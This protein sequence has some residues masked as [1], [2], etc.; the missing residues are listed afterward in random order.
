MYLES[1]WLSVTNLNTVSHA[2]WLS[3]S[4]RPP[5]RSPISRELRLRRE[6]FFLR[7]ELFSE[8]RFKQQA[9]HQMHSSV[10]HTLVLSKAQPPLIVKGHVLDRAFGPSG[11]T[12]RLIRRTS[13]PSVCW[14]SNVT[15]LYPAAISSVK[16]QADIT[17][18]TFGCEDDASVVITGACAGV[19]QCGNGNT[20]QCKGSVEGALCNCTEACARDGCPSPPSPPPP[21]PPMPPEDPDII[22]FL[23]PPGTGGT[24]MCAWARELEQFSATTGVRLGA[25][26]GFGKGACL[27][28]SCAPLRYNSMWGPDR[29]KVNIHGCGRTCSQLRQHMKQHNATWGMLES[30]MG[31]EWPC[32]N[33]VDAILLREPWTRFAHLIGDGDSDIQRHR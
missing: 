22:R 23:H 18:D 20:T 26:P 15:E 24:T 17:I 1:S 31:S 6:L 29:R 2:L 13:H 28:G 21:S 27:M 33:V 10:L 4:R 8:K 5:H 12:A 25:I 32:K 14:P 9:S 30:E 7:R 16:H 11:C 19:F 3:G